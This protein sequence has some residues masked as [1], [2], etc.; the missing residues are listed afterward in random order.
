[1][2]NAKANI[3]SSGLAISLPTSRLPVMSAASSETS[4]AIARAIARLHG[5][6]ASDKSQFIVESTEI[7]QSPGNLYC[8]I[9]LLHN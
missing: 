5:S 1:M 2:P 8:F 4:V 9:M 7:F 3:V 6:W